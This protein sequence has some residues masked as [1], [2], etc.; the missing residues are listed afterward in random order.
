MRLAHFSITPP[1]ESERRRCEYAKRK[2]R[3]RYRG[4][5]KE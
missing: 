1:K 3:K 4:V 2:S 5:T